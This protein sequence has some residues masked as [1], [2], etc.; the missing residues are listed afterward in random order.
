MRPIF[1]VSNASS[2]LPTTAAANRTTKNTNKTA[3][4]DLYRHHDCH[5]PLTKGM[6]RKFCLSTVAWMIVLVLF[7][8]MNVLILPS[9]TGLNTPDHDHR[10]R[11]RR[12]YQHSDTERRMNVGDGVY[13]SDDPHRYH[14]RKRLPSRRN[15]SPHISFVPVDSLT[16][17]NAPMTSRI[18]TAKNNKSDHRLIYF[19]HIHKSGGSTM[20]QTA[21][22]NHERTNENHNCNVQSDQRCCGGKDSLQAQ[23][24]FWTAFRHRYSFVANEGDMYRAMDTA[25]YRYVVQLRDSRARYFSHWQHVYRLQ[26]PPA[27]NVTFSEWYKLQPDNWNL[28][29]ICGTDC[30]TIPKYGISRQVFEQTVERLLKFDHVLFVE[31]FNRS[32]TDFAKAV[33]W[34][35]LPVFRPPVRSIQYPIDDEPWDPLMSALDDALY[36]IA[37]QRFEGR[38]SLP[39]P[40]EMEANTAKYFREGSTRACSNPCCGPKCSKY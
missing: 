23:R 32:F 18:D 3:M 5:P 35:L 7:S 1:W 40:S 17:G 11:G 31:D 10:S 29:K 22:V 15:A 2:S 26:Q 8:M 19:L 14:T 21:R 38:A 27:K 9:I 20:C 6:L 37:K 24:S 4:K 13:F 12:G 39:L 16:T 25:R 33:N 30:Q 34:P 36:T 28:R